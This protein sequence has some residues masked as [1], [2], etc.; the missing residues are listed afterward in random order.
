[1]AGLVLTMVLCSAGLAAGQ[2][3]QPRTFAIGWT[4]SYVPDSF[5]L[6]STTNLTV[7]L[8][9]WTVVAQI[10]NPVL[11]QF[12]STNFGIVTTATIYTAATSAVV[13]CPVGSWFYALTSSNMWG[14]WLYPSNA[15]NAVWT[16]PA[17]APVN[18]LGIK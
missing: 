15:S 11:Q 8:S 12:T 4:N 6:L 9:N 18:S 10:P 13:Q 2:G 14:L 7:P 3:T 5:V 17:P 16:P 1:M